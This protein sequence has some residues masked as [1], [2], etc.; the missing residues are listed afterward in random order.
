MSATSYSVSGMSCGHCADAIKG[1][2]T[3]LPGIDTVDVDVAAGRVTVSGGG[4][5]AVDAI[6]DAIDDAGYE[7]VEA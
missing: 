5:T 1:S 4:A 2:L 7:L 6:Q 3:A